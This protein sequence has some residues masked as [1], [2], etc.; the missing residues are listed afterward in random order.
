VQVELQWQMCRLDAI[1]SFVSFSLRSDDKNKKKSDLKFHVIVTFDYE[2]LPRDTVLQIEK[3]SAWW[4]WFVA[5][6]Y[7]TG[8]EVNDHQIFQQQNKKIIENWGQSK[9]RWQE[10]DL[11]DSGQC[12]T[13]DFTDLPNHVNLEWTQNILT[14]FNCLHQITFGCCQRIQ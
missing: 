6:R 3:L 9:G 7:K 13:I 2:N 5:R 10:Q 4:L 8:L 11:H 1:V 12:W 14:Y